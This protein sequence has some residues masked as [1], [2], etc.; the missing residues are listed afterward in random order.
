MKKKIIAFLFAVIFCF[1]AFPV[2]AFAEVTNEFGKIDESNV[3]DD[4]SKW[5]IDITKY[6][7]DTDATHGR[8]L[9]FL[10][11]GFDYYGNESSYGLYVY[12]WN[13]SGKPLD[14]TS[15]NHYIQM[16]VKRESGSATGSGWRKHKLQVCNYSSIDGYE[17]V[18]Y[19]FKVLDI[20]VFRDTLSRDFRHYEIS[21]VELRHSGDSNSTDYKVGGLYSFT[22]FMPY[23]NAQRNAANSLHWY[24]RDRTAVDIKLTPV[25]WKTTTSDKGAYYQYE[26][27]SVYFSVPNDIIRDYGDKNDA[28]KGLVEIH[29]SFEEYKINGL[30]TPYNDV[31]NTAYNYIGKKAS[32]SDPPFGF[33]GGYDNFAGVANVN[34]IKYNIT[35]PVEGWFNLPGNPLYF[36]K[37][38]NRLSSV[39]HYYGDEFE[40]I[41]SSDFKEDLDDIRADFGGLPVF[42]EVDAG[43][44]KGY[45][46]YTV[47]DT[48]DLGM[49]IASYASNHS[50]FV[51]WLRNEYNLVLESKNY[52]KIN[53][54]EAVD[55]SKLLVE[56]TFLKDSA[57]AEKY[58]MQESEA[59]QF[60]DDVLSWENLGDTTFIMRY[61]VRDYYCTPVGYRGHGLAK[62]YNAEDGNYYFEKTIFKNLDIWTFTWENQYNERTTIPVVCSPIDSVGSITPPTDP[63]NFAQVEQVVEK[64][65]D[66]WKNLK[67]FLFDGLGSLKTIF[68]V[69]LLVVFVLIVVWLLS[70]LLPL[71]YGGSE[72]LRER[73]EEKRRDQELDLKKQEMDLKREKA[74]SDDLSRYSKGMNVSNEMPD[75]GREVVRHE[76]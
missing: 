70:K 71:L 22:G 1:L 75:R 16:Q 10:E 4:L 43:H 19:K 12:F 42:S 34:G 46:E 49:Q 52:G 55:K 21:G 61:A 5:G 35:F 68:V 30:V 69:I 64:A 66:I 3:L 39:L 28:T 47:K 72:L 38:I 26:L 40:G 24:V 13:P 44:T 48:D 65:T 76:E 50:S 14:L 9:R 33:A 8:M 36:N 18:F 20:R 58:F 41:S 51:A 67:D 32:E 53:G 60:K 11:Y 29:G 73:R 7:K 63:D 56:G 25:T 37:E 59:G 45:Q 15:T 62:N 6:K 23:C 17:H 57:I 2:S 74:R 27:S 31:Y 54:I